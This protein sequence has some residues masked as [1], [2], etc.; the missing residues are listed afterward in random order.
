MTPP[1]IARAVALLILRDLRRLVRRPSQ[2]VATAGLPLIFAFVLGSGFAEMR[3]TGG[4][5]PD[6]GY[7]A[8]LVPGAALLAVVFAATFAGMGLIE[9]RHE[10]ALRAIALSPAPPWALAAAR[11]LSTAI[12]ALLPAGLILA[13]GP[14]MT[15][16][17]IGPG[18]LVSLAALAL[19]SVAIGGVSLALAWLIDSSRGFHGVLNLGLMP[20]WLL[21]GAVFPVATASGWVAL[22]AK[23]NPLGWTHAAASASLGLEPAIPPWA[24]WAG[25]IA[26]AMVGA[27]LAVASLSKQKG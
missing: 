23:I 26:V 21:S 22:L 27:A 1:A 15:G 25:S 10:G 24:A 20:A 18:L 4:E 19:A 14:P 7:A 5:S 6:A 13:L 12:L 8:Y 2:I 17:A 3:F 11:L 9:D 16:L